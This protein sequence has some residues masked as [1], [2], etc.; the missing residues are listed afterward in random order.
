MN[1]MRT[2][3]YFI[4]VFLII[5]VQVQAQIRGQVQFNR[6]AINTMKENSFDK[7][8]TD[9][10]LFIEDPGSPELPI[11]LKSYLIPV[12]ADKVTVNVQN[13]SKQEIKG[14]YN[15]YPAQPPVLTGNVNSIFTTSNPKIY[16]SN[17]PYPGKQAEIISDGIYMGYR[18]ITVRLYPVEYIP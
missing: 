6:E 18:I 12:D 9:E 5:G 16:E 13:E 17:N 2:K 8:I 15:V 1:I 7:I 3:K 4:L 10:N 14:Q 11:L